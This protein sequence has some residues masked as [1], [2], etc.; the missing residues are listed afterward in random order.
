[1]S[2]YL[3]R[4]VQANSFSTDMV[5]NFSLLWGLPE[6]HFPTTLSLTL[7]LEVMVMRMKVINEG[8]GGGSW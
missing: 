1:M 3:Q 8:L 7:C 6:C 4:L 5:E 2:G